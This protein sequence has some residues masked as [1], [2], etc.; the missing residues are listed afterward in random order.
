ME[1]QES[2]G[3]PHDLIMKEDV[4]KALRTHKGPKAKLRNYSI[5]DFASKGENYLGAITSVIVYYFI[6]DT[7]YDTSYIVKMNPCRSSGFTKFSKFLFEKEIYFYTELIPL[8]DACLAAMNEPSLKLPKCYYYNEKQSKEVIYL[9]DLRN[10]G[11]VLYTKD[12]MDKQHTEMILQEL[13][14]LHASSAIL[15]EKENLSTEDVLKRFPGLHEGML[16]LHGEGSS[17]QLDSFYS[18]T[19][20]NTA[21]VTDM[22]EG[23][24][25]ISKTLR[26]WKVD[27][28]KRYLREL[29]ARHPFRVICHG[30]AW[31]NNFLFKYV[32][33][34][35]FGAY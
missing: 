5:K 28:L 21:K 16:G 1:R 25:E 30:D 31:T 11:Y 7:L 27:V 13:A 10:S 26:S 6:D 23:Y 24:E 32:S 3:D 8:L 2:Y 20:E 18:T 33:K 4:K 14:R 34:K 22:C 35:V 29:E 19:L 17:V 9:E 15:V 12:G